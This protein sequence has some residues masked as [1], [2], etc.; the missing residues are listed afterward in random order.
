[1][2]YNSAESLPDNKLTE[3]ITEKTAKKI[4]M[5]NA[6][7]LWCIVN[8]YEEIT[9]DGGCDISFIMCGKRLGFIFEFDKTTEELKALAEAVKNE[10]SFIYTVINDSRKRREVIKLIPPEYG[11]FC[12]SNSFG[13]GFVY[14]IFREPS[15]IY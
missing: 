12:Y 5:A 7:R 3:S 6:V 14:Q 11:I 4:R 15:L 9:D 13:L 2:K 8:G 1:M 10:Y